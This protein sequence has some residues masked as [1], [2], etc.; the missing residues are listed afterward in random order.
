M[1]GLIKAIQFI[2]ILSTL[3]LTVSNAKKPNFIIFLADDMGYGDISSHG[4]PS[5]EY[6]AIDKL[7]AEGMRFTHWYSADVVCTPSRAALLTGRYPLR[8]GLSGG[9]RVLLPHHFSGLPKSE[10]TI[11]E[12]LKD[13][14]YNTGIVGKWHLGINEATRTDG[15]HLPHNHGF[16]Y[17]GS[18]LPFT[19]VWDCDTS[20][21][22]ME[23]ANRHRCFLYQ[24]TTIIQQPIDLHNLSSRF[25]HD[26]KAFLHDN[27][28]HPFFLY[29]PLPQTHTPMFNMPQF[30]NKS[31]RGRYGDQINEMAWTISEIM[32]TLK[33]LRLDED[34]LVLFLSDHGPHSEVCSEGGDAGMLRGGKL[35]FFEGGIR[36]PAI[37]H[38][39]GKIKP[40]S[41][42]HDVISTMDIFPTILELAGAKEQ[43]QLLDGQSITDILFE[44]G[45]KSHEILFYHLERD[46]LAVRY[47]NFK[48][49][50]KAAGLPT[51]KFIKHFCPGGFPTK[52][53]MLGEN[54]IVALPFDSPLVYDVERD[55]GERYPLNPRDYD[56]VIREVREEIAKHFATVTPTKCLLYGNH[57]NRKVIPCCN[58]PYCF[59]N[60]PGTQQ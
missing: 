46:V 56:N 36:V 16:N 18:I 32:D 26:A 10:I 1:T 21:V 31:R 59:C 38:W 45:H 44:K 22:H 48:I 57:A 54:H 34:T 25:L 37:A 39:P 7:A 11:A 47:N 17:V 30:A 33:T 35:S 9:V 53:V 29:Y 3:F 50:F 24:N 23:E 60:F 52:S 49:H 51:E 41:V 6:G 4:H 43:D 40:A 5:Q 42:S 19:L 58:P 14:G 27:A 28:D 12:A 2:T 8:Y 13:V 15:G 20:K 55:P